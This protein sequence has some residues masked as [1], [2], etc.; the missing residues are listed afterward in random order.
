MEIT[1]YLMSE[2]WTVSRRQ[3]MMSDVQISK[4]KD[5]YIEKFDFPYSADGQ[6]LIKEH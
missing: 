2:K 6:Q 1:I 3:L 4:D 5:I